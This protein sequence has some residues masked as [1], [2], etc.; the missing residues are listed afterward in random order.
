MATQ[1]LRY[2]SR[3]KGKDETAA[4]SET[5]DLDL[6]TSILDVSHTE[7]GNSQA[8]KGGYMKNTDITTAYNYD[9]FVPAKF[10]PWMN[11]D[12]SPALGLAA[13]DC[14]SPYWICC[15]WDS[16]RRCPSGNDHHRPGIT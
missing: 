5:S 14:F 12:N 1:P 4:S 15:F 16:G 13:P 10:I 6:I 7:P 2:I 11:F 8:M 3:V 9:E